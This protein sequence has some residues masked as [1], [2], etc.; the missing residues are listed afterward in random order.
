[1]AKALTC[2][3]ARVSGLKA[4]SYFTIAGFVIINPN[5]NYQ[6]HLLLVKTCLPDRQAPTTA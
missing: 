4:R 2:F 6:P 1:L 3:S 5:E